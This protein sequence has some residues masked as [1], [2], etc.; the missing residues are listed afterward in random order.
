MNLF[1]ADVSVLVLDL[2][3]LWVRQTNIKVVVLSVP[4]LVRDLFDVWA[5]L[6]IPLGQQDPI[7]WVRLFDQDVIGDGALLLL[8]LLLRL[9]LLVLRLLLVRF[10]FGGGDVLIEQEEQ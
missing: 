6:P 2:F 3:Q 8:L 5:P 4:R 1:V 7:L 10:L 9:L